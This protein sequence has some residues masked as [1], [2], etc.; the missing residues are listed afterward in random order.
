[1]LHCFK[2]SINDHKRYLKKNNKLQT[3]FHN[4]STQGSERYYNNLP[5]EILLQK[6]WE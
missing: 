5:Y 4:S 3:F 1:M 2:W 6:R